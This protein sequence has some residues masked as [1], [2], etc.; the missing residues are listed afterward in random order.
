MFFNHASTYRVILLAVLSFFFAGFS[1]AQTDGIPQDD[2]QKLVQSLSDKVVSELNLNREA[3]ESNPQE[4][5]IFATTYVLPYID[6]VKMARYVMGKH[7]RSASE[8]QQK[9]FV[10]AFTNTLI[11]SYS[12]SLLKLKIESVEVEPAREEKPGRVTVASK[13]LQ[14][15]GNK[16]DVIYRVYLNKHT[17]KW[18]L[19]DVAV[20]GISMLLSYRKAYDSDITKKGLDAVISE[21]QDKNADFNGSSQS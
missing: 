11:R 15:D 10:D 9:G 17:N 5:K 2:P 1:Q 19:Y 4:V 18:M 8:V 13:V 14:S 3:L 16:S 12:Q 6:T 7:W 20:E 21:M